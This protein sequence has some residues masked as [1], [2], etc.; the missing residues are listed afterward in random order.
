MYA[1]IDKHDQTL[2]ERIKARIA[3]KKE[4]M[5]YGVKTVNGKKK[6]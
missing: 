2:K 5:R 4:T 3:K 6:L 1:V